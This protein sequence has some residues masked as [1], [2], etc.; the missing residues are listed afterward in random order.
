MTK[1]LVLR[2]TI[3]TT[4]RLST[5][6]TRVHSVMDPISAWHWWTDIIIV[7]CRLKKLLI[8]WTS[9]YWKSDTVWLWHHPT[10]W[11]RL[12]T[13]MGQGS[14]PGVNQSRIQLE[15]VNLLSPM[16]DASNFL[17]CD[18]LYTVYF[19]FYPIQWLFMILFCFLNTSPHPLY[20]TLLN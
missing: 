1:T 15:M 18:K 5:R 2:S 9:A 14:M 8:W 17:S 20:P 11:S 12:S 7:A 16:N 10:L 4:L 13:R 6:L 3:L 19:S